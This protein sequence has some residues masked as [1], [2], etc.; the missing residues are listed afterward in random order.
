MPQDYAA[1]KGTFPPTMERMTSLPLGQSKRL[2]EQSGRIMKFA[3]PWHPMFESREPTRFW[4]EYG[5]SN[6]DLD[7]SLVNNLV[8]HK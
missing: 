4:D 5:M 8:P 7:F 3:R 6:D 1:S 2:L